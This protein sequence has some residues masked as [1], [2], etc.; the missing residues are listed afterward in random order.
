M[1]LG[2]N[3]NAIDAERTAIEAAQTEI[4]TQRQII[5]TSRT[6]ERA[7]L[8]AIEQD[9]RDAN[10]NGLGSVFS[11]GFLDAVPAGTVQTFE[12]SNA[13]RRLTFQY[14]KD[15]DRIFNIV[16]TRFPADRDTGS[17]A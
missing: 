12:R 10:I 8:E 1:A 2:A 9:I 5:Q 7:L 11:V 16:Y 13:Q 15:A 6:S 3:L 14:D 17:I 4:Q